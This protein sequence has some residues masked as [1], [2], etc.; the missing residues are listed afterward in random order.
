MGHAIGFWIAFVATVLLLVVSLVAGLR[1]R[2]RL[3]LV[4]GPLTIAMLAVTVVATKDLIASYSFPPDDLRFHLRFAITAGAAALPVVATG[5]WLWRQPRARRWHRLAVWT[6][7]V[8]TVVAT[9]TGV[10]L[11]SR[12]TLKA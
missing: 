12:A 10:W 4:T 3:H 8:L 9:S 6:F 7:V 2:R 1:G 11:F 5:V